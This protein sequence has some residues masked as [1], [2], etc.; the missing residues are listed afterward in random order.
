MQR[1]RVRPLPRRRPNKQRWQRATG[2]AL[3]G[4]KRVIGCSAGR[5]GAQ[6]GL[7]NTVCQVGVHGVCPVR[8]GSSVIPEAGYVAF[9]SATEIGKA[10][11][12]ATLP[13]VETH[14]REIGHVLETKPA[15][16]IAYVLL[17][18]N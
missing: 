17:H 12:T 10:N 13:D 7:Q 16:G 5:V 6:P 4:R 1:F 18:F 2:T 11:N 9:V 14:N 8:F 15:G 3:G